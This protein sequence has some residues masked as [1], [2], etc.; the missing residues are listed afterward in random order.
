MEAIKSFR[1]DARAFLEEKK[2]PLAGDE[3]S[4]DQLQ[5]KD[6]TFRACVKF[7]ND[8]SSEFIEYLSPQTLFAK[9]HLKTPLVLLTFSQGLLSSMV[10]TFFKFHGE[11]L[12]S[13][14]LGF[15]TPLEFTLLMSGV[16]VSGILFLSLNVGIQ[17]YE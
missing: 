16:I 7:I 2:K 17:Y 11:I 12:Q 14:E 5:L 15:W 9:E 13:G 3:T 8:S 10:Y 1:K 6:P 4:D